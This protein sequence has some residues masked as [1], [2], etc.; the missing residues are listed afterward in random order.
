MRQSGTHDEGFALTFLGTRGEIEARSRRHRRHSALLL[1]RGHSRI[2]MDCGADWLRR[3][4][5]LKPTAIVLTH[6]HP[7]HARGL[8]LG[9]PCPVYATR[10]TWKSLSTYPVRERR[11]MPLRKSV[12]I[13]RIKFEAFPVEHSLRAPAVGYRIS[14]GGARFFYVPDLVAIRDRGRALQGI[15]L[16]IGDGAMIKRP[17]VRKRK[18]TLIGHTSIRRQLAWCRNE[19]VPTAFFTHCGTEIVS[20]DARRLDRVVHDM[21]TECGVNAYIAHD[22][23]RLLLHRRGAS[24]SRAR[25]SRR[26]TKH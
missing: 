12:T 16:Y 14:A 18:G 13:G 8:A 19:G 24:L 17:L 2:M 15:D 23:R 25:Y 1:R 3:V 7:D 11:I 20:G 6:A 9:A 26:G 10:K 4:H 22:G 5:E 21:G